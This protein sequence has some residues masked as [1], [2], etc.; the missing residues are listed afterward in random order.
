MH[1]ATDALSGWIYGL[2]LLLAFV[3]AVRLVAGPAAPAG[4]PAAT[5]AEPVAVPPAR[6]PAVPP[7]RAPAGEVSR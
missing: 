5:M 6:A 4:R 3:T 1:W 2:L 7:A